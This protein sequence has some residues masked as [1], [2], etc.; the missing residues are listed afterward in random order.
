LILK[1]CKKS[2]LIL[3]S[4]F[5]ATMRHRI[6][7]RPAPQAEVD[8]IEEVTTMLQAE[9]AHW[10]ANGDA[11]EAE[12]AGV[13]AEI[14]FHKAEIAP[15][16]EDG[17]CHRAK[18]KHA[19]LL[20]A[21]DAKENL[22]NAKTDG[23]KT[24]TEKLRDE[25]EAKEGEEKRLEGLIGAAKACLYGQ[26]KKFN[27][28]VDDCVLEEVFE[29]IVQGR[30]SEEE[31]GWF[32]SP[33]SLFLIW[34][35][36]WKF[37][38]RS[39]R[40]ISTPNP[41][42]PPDAV[43]QVGDDGG[44]DQGFGRGSVELAGAV[45]GLEEQFKEFVKEMAEVRGLVE[46]WKG[47]TKKAKGKKKSRKEA[48]RGGEV[49]RRNEEGKEGKGEE[50]GKGNGEIEQRSKW[51]KV[52]ME[53]EIEEKVNSQEEDDW[54]EKEAQKE[55]QGQEEEKGPHER[56]SQSVAEDLLTEDSRSDMLTDL[57]SGA[58]ILSEKEKEL[59]DL[60]EWPLPPKRTSWVMVQR[61]RKRQKL[62]EA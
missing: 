60:N 18:A 47:K 48:E 52:A 14:A 16:K 31:Y 30:M 9:I 6:P 13:D 58:G 29:V 44:D 20:D 36:E 35:H 43:C 55:A 24:K 22:L 40:L 50:E 17:S 49:M 8:P 25:V 10:K 32:F 62:A 2:S 61:E 45:R 15:H 51:R 59:V 34:T 23:L 41:P 5:A 28:E 19:S 7:L 42:H 46:L 54:K 56:V 38:H 37:K 27:S 21:N 1:Y 33:P 3:L 12:K 11:L 53:D 57:L 39:R 26:V 4:Q